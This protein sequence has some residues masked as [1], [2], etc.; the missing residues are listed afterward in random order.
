MKRAFFS[1]EVRFFLRLPFVAP[2][3]RHKISGHRQFHEIPRGPSGESGAR[4]RSAPLTDSPACRRP[5]AP[6]SSRFHA[7]CNPPNRPIRT[8]TF[9]S[10]G[11]Y[12]K[13]IDGR[14]HLADG[15]LP[16]GTARQ[17][18]SHVRVI[19][20]KVPQDSSRHSNDMPRPWFR[21]TCSAPAAPPL[22]G[23]YAGSSFDRGDSADRP[24]WRRKRRS[25]CLEMRGQDPMRAFVAVF[26]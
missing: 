2:F 11:T 22:Q 7:P 3:R 9:T 18:L 16:C 10:D 6:G 21:I 14:Q 26:A 4:L 19:A 17:P 24:R 8:V 13:K 12:T 20:S 5:V 25:R 15:S 1:I 23:C